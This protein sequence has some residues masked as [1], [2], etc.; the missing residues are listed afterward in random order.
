V[1]GEV[2]EVIHVSLDAPFV[3]VLGF[4][5]VLS[6]SFNVGGGS[7]DSD[8]GDESNFVE[9]F[10][11]ILKFELYLRIKNSSFKTFKPIKSENFFN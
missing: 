11:F 8:G 6:S 1:L 9:H 2:V 3:A 4:V 10:M 5:A 7:S